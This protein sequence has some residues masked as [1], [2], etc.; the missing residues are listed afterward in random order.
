M[1]KVAEHCLLIPNTLRPAEAGGGG[2]SRS[3]HSARP[4]M[5]DCTKNLSPS[6]NFPSN[7]WDDNKNKLK[8]HK[9]MY[10]GVLEAKIPLKNEP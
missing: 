9:S 8:F 1:H 5:R 7:S 10:A 3:A 6:N 4:G 2:F